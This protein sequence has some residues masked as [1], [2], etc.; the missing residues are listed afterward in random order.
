MVDQ[1]K[2]L[3]GLGRLGARWAAIMLAGFCSVN[4]IDQNEIDQKT[5]Q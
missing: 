5:E 2:A 1:C 4:Y 3:S